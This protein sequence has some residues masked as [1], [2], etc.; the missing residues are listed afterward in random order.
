MEVKDVRS[1][2]VALFRPE[3][4]ANSSG[5]SREDPHNEEKFKDMSHLHRGVQGGRTHH[6]ATL[7]AHLSPLLH[8]RVDEKV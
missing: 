7:Q 8:Q 5:E 4:D 2:Y 1:C 6:E 3:V